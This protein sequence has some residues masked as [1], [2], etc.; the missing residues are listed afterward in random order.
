MSYISMAFMRQSLVACLC[1][2]VW[3][4]ASAETVSSFESAL[5]K[6]QSYQAQNEQWQQIQK[7]QN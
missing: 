7:V 6:V 5:A 3:Q 1:A 2:A 4:A